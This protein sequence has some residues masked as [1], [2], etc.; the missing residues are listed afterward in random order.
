MKSVYSSKHIP[1]YSICL[2]SSLCPKLKSPLIP[3]S[4]FRGYLTTKKK[5]KKNPNKLLA[6]V[7]NFIHIF[8]PSYVQE[9]SHDS[10]KSNNLRFYTAGWVKQHFQ[11]LK[12]SK[13]AFGHIGNGFLGIIT[14]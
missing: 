10:K 4:W 7:F 11:P 5:K 8:D 1:S 9:M 2:L 13:F 3:F 14:L 6:S 12:F